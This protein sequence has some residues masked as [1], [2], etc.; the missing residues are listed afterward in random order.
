MFGGGGA[1]RIMRIRGVNVEMD[2]TALLLIAFFTF[3]LA[4]RDFPYLYHEW[5]SGLI[6]LAAIVIGVMIVGSILAHELSHAL[7]G[8]ALGAQVTGIR[9]F[10]F[11]GATYFSRKSMS[12]GKDFLIS[13]A[14]PLSNLALGGIFYVLEQITPAREV[15]HVVSG[16]LV[17]VNIGL[18]I[19]NLL[20]GFPMDGGQALRS[21][22]IVLTK[23]ESLAALVV[24]I[25]GCIVGG[26]LALLA[27]NSLVS[28]NLLGAIWTGLIAFWIISGSLKQYYELPNYQPKSALGRLLWSWRRQDRPSN[29]PIYPTNKVQPSTH[30]NDVVRA[31]QIMS[32]V[33]AVYPPAT[34]VAQ[35]LTD[36]AQ[37]QLPDLQD[38]A[39]INYGQLVG[40]V[41]R[42]M[43]LA[44]PIQDQP[45]I[46]LNQICAPASYFI[47]VNI[48]EDLA[49]VL[50]AMNQQPDRPIT[51]YETSGRFA[52]LI[53]R[54]DLERYLNNEKSGQ[55]QEERRDE[56]GVGSGDNQPANPY[57]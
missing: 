53:S 39:V 6:W 37:R 28:N 24:A 13:I 30:Y 42:A 43:A 11:G 48:N 35:F 41:T 19:F 17:W 46:A 8:M 34:T 45:E 23:R 26:L 47:A 31:Y 16:Y 51:V 27:A 55:K 56:S 7:V 15:V 4:T 5:G 38:T 36:T 33:E 3:P 40:L 9:L 52:G 10:I 25:S 32:K 2:V 54:S 20:P 18:G 50:K 14:G 22:V 44:V 49:T 12:E 57:L 21:A 1:F 29:V